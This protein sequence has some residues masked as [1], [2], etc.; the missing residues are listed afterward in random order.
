MSIRTEFW[1]E[2]ATLKTIDLSVKIIEYRF[3]LPH[4]YVMAFSPIIVGIHV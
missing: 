1:K 2:A 3:V 4:R